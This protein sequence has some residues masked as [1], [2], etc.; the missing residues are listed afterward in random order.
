MG[1]KKIHDRIPT[2]DKMLIPTLQALK[3]LETIGYQLLV[4]N[5]IMEKVSTYTPIFV[6]TIPLNTDIE[7]SGI[8]IICYRTI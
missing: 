5:K 3:Q 8:D 2:Y 4:K 6:G 7:T 1:R